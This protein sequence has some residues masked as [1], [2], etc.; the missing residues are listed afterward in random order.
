MNPKT[1]SIFIDLEMTYTQLEHVVR[2]RGQTSKLMYI[3]ALQVEKVLGW[4]LY[5]TVAGFLRKSYFRLGCLC[6][7]RTG[8]FRTARVKPQGRCYVQDGLGQCSANGIVSAKEGS[9]E[10]RRRIGHSL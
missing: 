8:V 7:L 4:S 9:E 1:V 5:Y 6:V 2:F 10:E 3:H